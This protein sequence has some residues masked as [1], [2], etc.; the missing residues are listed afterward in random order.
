MKYSFLADEKRLIA[1]L[2]ASGFREVPG[3]RPSSVYPY[4]KFFLPCPVGTFSN[5]TSQGAEGCI[6]CPPGN[7]NF[8]QI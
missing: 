6:P 3:D 1:A 7:L 8:I 2:V 5:I 4:S